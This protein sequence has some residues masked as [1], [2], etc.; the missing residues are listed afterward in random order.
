MGVYH[1]VYTLTAGQS[2]RVMPGGTLRW[3]IREIHEDKESVG[4]M[5]GY[6]EDSKLPP[7]APELIPITPYDDDSQ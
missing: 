3:E 1:S 7:K 6:I 4:R 5:K 2:V